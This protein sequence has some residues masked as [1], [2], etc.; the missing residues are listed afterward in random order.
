MIFEKLGT[1]CDFSKIFFGK[2]FFGRMFFE[3]NFEFLKKCFSTFK[4][5]FWKNVFESS[6]GFFKIQKCFSFESFNNQKHKF[7]TTIFQ[8]NVFGFWQSKTVVQL[9]K[10][11][12]LI[13]QQIYFG[14]SITV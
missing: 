5:S 4:N 2:A 3:N 10:K 13:E 6:F 1:S 7:R 12:F 14:V 8:K 9:L 11:G